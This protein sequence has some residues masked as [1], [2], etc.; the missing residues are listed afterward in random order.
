MQVDLVNAVVLAAQRPVNWVSF[1]VPQAR[2]DAG[3]FA[4]LRDLTAGPQTELDF[5]LVP[6]HPD[7]Q[8]DGTTDEQAKQIETALSE[9]A[10]GQRE[11]GIC[12]ECGMG[13]VA[14]DDVPKLLD[15]HREILTA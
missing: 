6:Y 15:L 13:R 3:C 11:W 5:A 8:A 4:P 7:D 1:T 9:S 12:T 2:N 10:A 14:A